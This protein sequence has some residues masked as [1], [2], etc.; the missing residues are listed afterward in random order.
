MQR[1]PSC[2]LLPVLRYLQD[3]NLGHHAGEFEFIAVICFWVKVVSVSF[4]SD[5][6]DRILDL[7]VYWPIMSLNDRP[8]MKIFQEC[9]PIFLKVVFWD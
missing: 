4:I 1:Y 3:L 6:S 7:W 5:S 8:E 9:Y 2:G